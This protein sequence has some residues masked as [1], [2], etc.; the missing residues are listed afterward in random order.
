MQKGA[1]LRAETPLRRA[2]M[3]NPFFNAAD[4]G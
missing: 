4:G 2:G 1:C 3:G